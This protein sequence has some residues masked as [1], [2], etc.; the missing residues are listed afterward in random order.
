MRIAIVAPTE[1][2]ARRANTMQIMK[3]AQAIAAVGH[4]VRVAAPRTSGDKATPDTGVLTDSS[5][6]ELA[7]HY[8]LRHTFP[9]RWLPAARRLRRYDYSLRAVIWA[10]RWG[11]EVLYTRLPQAAS[12]ASQLGLRT[13]LEV[14]DMSQ[15]RA[16]AWLLRRFMRGRGAW[17][18]VVI[19]R[20]LADDLA[21]RFELPDKPSFTIIAP[22]GVD[23]E[24]YTGLPGASE[25]RQMLI[26]PGGRRL[27]ERFT[28]GYTGH[29]YPGRGS[30]LLL[31]LAARL[32][33]VTFLVVGGEEADVTRLQ[34]EARARQL[35]N[36]VLTGFVPNA[37]LPRYQ[38]AC[39]ALLMPYQRRV[40]ASSG[41]D[42]A[43]YL[44]PMKLFEYM[45]CGR[46]ILSSDLPVLQEILTSGHED[47][48]QN[49]ILLPPEDVGDWE[50]ALRSLI[51]DSAL[52]L[53]LAAQARHDVEAF[54][55][56]ARAVKIFGSGKME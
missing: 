23:L 37:E 2:P 40:A 3:M 51:V 22:D 25:A 29:L 52:R 27:P 48:L 24:R 18:L 13:V 10:F 36:F 19:T 5:W 32:P 15:G 21:Q 20:A 39:E 7:H 16:W 8:G 14:H 11:A 50:A 4:E 41:G 6:Q 53:R 44:S 17:R 28:A 38:A 54:T 30:D 1:I 49:A 43:R 26:L 31:G 46:A 35:D 47:R 42:I 56:E 12:V 55:W 45:A 33:E 9:I 34:G